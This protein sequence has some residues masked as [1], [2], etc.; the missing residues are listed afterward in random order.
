M[1]RGLFRIYWDT[2]GRH[3]R[4][5]LWG[6]LALLAVNLLDLTPPLIV[7]FVVDSVREK[8]PDMTLLVVALSFMG[9]ILLQNILRY[10][11][12]MYFRGTAVRIIADLRERYASHLLRLPPAFYTKQT[13]GDLMSRA[14]NDMEAVDRAM[15][16]G[17]LLVV[18]TVI[19]L[20]TIPVVM[21]FLSPGLTLYA[22]ALMPLVPIFVYFVSRVIEKRF[23]EVQNIYGEMTAHAQQNAAGVQVVRA[24]GAEQPQIDAFQEKADRFMRRSLSLARIEALFW[25]AINLF[26]GFGMFAVLY[27]GGGKVLMQEISLGALVAFV[28]Y[29]HKLI[30]PLMTLGWTITLT[31]RGRA[32]LNR[33]HAVLDTPPA[34]TDGTESMERARGTVEFIEPLVSV[35]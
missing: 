30:W 21:S 2:A 19:Y 18:D 14:S 24:Y 17:F 27:F 4:L 22:F 33:I 12:R 23:E 28:H 13:T 3:R 11:M 8:A 26:L 6:T 5:Y 29:M 25:P 7:K 9:I 32:S 20:S 35:G 34:I 1:K 10:P 15:G 31:Q 16:L